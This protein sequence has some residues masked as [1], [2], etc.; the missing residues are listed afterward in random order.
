MKRNYIKLILLVAM[1]LMG[2]MSI[3]VSTANANDNKQQPTV[4]IATVTGTP[5][6]PMVRV[7][8][9]QEFANVRSGPGTQ[10]AKVGVLVSGQIVPAVGK[11]GF[12][13]WIQVAYPGVEG[14][15]GWVYS[16]LVIFIKSGDLP[17]IEP[18]TE[19]TPLVTPTIDPTFAAQFIVESAATR[20]PTFTAPAPLVI[21]TLPVENAIEAGA[22]FPIGLVITLFGIVG[23]I[24]TLFSLLRGR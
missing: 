15:V 9:D 18:P 4:S 24:G 14:N 8:A 22:S 19:P 21:P 20:L 5:E 6:G 3:F 17:V 7:S 23:V 16:I 11:S 2:I 1:F 12:G 13:D 10:Y